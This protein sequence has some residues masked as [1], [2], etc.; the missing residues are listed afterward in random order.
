MSPKS[1]IAAGRAAS[2]AIRPWQYGTRTEN[3]QNV[4]HPR[5]SQVAR[6]RRRR[7]V[8]PDPALLP[9]S[10]MMPCDMVA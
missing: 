2:F 5:S 4:A 6:R 1:R 3:S 10:E 8:T 9:L 7:D